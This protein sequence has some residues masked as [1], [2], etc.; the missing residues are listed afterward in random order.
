M[1]PESLRDRFELLQPL[2]SGSR[3]TV[4]HVRERASGLDRVIK[5]SP[6]EWTT[7]REVVELARQ[8]IGHVGVV[9]PLESGVALDGRAYQILEYCPGG[10]LS[11]W[12]T[13]HSE[14]LTATERERI[15]RNVVVGL[16]PVLEAFAAQDD[17]A[18]QLVHGDI[19]PSNILISDNSANGSHYLLADFN[20]LRVLD[21]SN[22][23]ARI[24][25]RYAAPEGLSEASDL[26][27]LGMTLLECMTGEHPLAHISEHSARRL[28]KTVWKPDLS[29]IDGD[30]VR[31]LLAGLIE[32]NPERRWRGN[33]L[34]RWIEDDADI[35]SE[36]LA[37]CSETRAREPFLVGSVPCFTASD[38]ARQLLRS[39]DLDTLGLEALR[40]WIAGPLGRSDVAA[41]LEHLLEDAA[42]TPELRLLE[43]CFD[44]NPNAQPIWRQEAISRDRI[45]EA[46]LDVLQRAAGGEAIA[47]RG[48]RS[49]EWLES[50]LDGVCQRFY[51]DRL[52]RIG[53]MLAKLEQAIEQYSVAW[54]IAIQAGAPEHGRP[55]RAEL[56]AE[57]VRANCSFQLRRDLKQYR[58]RLAEIPFLVLLEDWTRCFGADLQKL[59]IPQLLVFRRLNPLAKLDTS[60]VVVESYV[61]DEEQRR[62]AKTGEP[63]IWPATQKRLLR[64]LVP[65]AG[66]EVIELIA[67]DSFYSGMLEPYSVGIERDLS[68]LW[69]WIV[70]RLGRVVQ[71]LRRSLLRRRRPEME[72]TP[73]HQA[74]PLVEERSPR[75]TLRMIRVADP[76][77][78][79]F[80]ANTGGKEFYMALVRWDAGGR[81]NAYLRIRRAG[82]GPRETRLLTPR[83]TE[84]GY[85]ALLLTGRCSIYLEQGHIVMETF[86]GAPLWVSRLTRPLVVWLSDIEP[87]ICSNTQTILA[88][89]ALR[90]QR[91]GLRPAQGR[92]AKV[93]TLVA[94]SGKLAQVDSRP[95]DRLETE[96]WRSRLADA[97]RRGERILEAR[98]QDIE[99]DL[100]HAET[101]TRKRAA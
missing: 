3:S 73:E 27:S 91:G 71:R 100:R 34:R 78:A 6:H 81:P 101:T 25:P 49:L 35:I 85:Y 84:R 70:Q 5:L 94:A 10:S 1:L 64:Q 45:D 21:V 46:A 75:L 24:T 40:E 98:E 62:A 44:L 66:S 11:T 95:L 12:L 82:F 93:P 56:I 14:T 28:I 76:V 22:H 33:E 20:T 48:Q 13:A 17:D 23:S 50:L 18:R 69:N 2:S 41:C 19:K 51:L 88:C 55:E 32:R 86:G 43:F 67:G 39:W 61:G 31:A 26:W 65:L 74:E 68:R 79:A 52:V 30:S 59:S 63:I 97:I 29:E 4:W 89:T 83:L 36:G 47:A 80:E 77:I 99:G 42:L 96:F 16:A 72:N 60:G 92:S 38:L 15:V 7:A 57:A 37:H 9:L 8:R 58:D 53:S 54:D 90:E 87:K